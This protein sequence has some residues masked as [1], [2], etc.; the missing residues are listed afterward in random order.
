VKVDSGFTEKE[1]MSDTSVSYFVRGGDAAS[2]VK[3]IVAKRPEEMFDQVRRV[4]A[5]EAAA[6]YSPVSP[7]APIAYSL[8]YLKDDT[9][10]AIGMS[11]EFL[12]NDCQIIGDFHIKLSNVDDG[13]ELY[14]NGR[15]EFEYFWKLDKYGKQIHPKR[16]SI[17][18]WLDEGDNELRIR[19]G[20]GGGGA[21][22]LDMALFN[23]QKV[24]DNKHFRKDLS[25]LG[26][27]LEWWYVLNKQ[28]GKAKFDE[29]RSWQ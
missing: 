17:N 8:R 13:V 1:I 10:A 16:Q 29:K 23:G 21:T 7:G 15:K 28:N 11:V 14:V 4:I 5:A 12:Q 20:N 25:H 18:Q 3:P 24:I 2:A 6:K 27:Q 26:W 9:S 19:L 22:A